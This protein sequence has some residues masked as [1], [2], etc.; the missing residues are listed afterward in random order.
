M[1]GWGCGVRGSWV[2]WVGRVKGLGGA[3]WFVGVVWGRGGVSGCGWRWCGGLGFV[4]G[5]VGWWSVVGWDVVGGVWCS[6]W[7]GCQGVG[8]VCLRGVWIVFG[9][10]RVGLLGVLGRLVVWGFRWWGWGRVVVVMWW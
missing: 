6:G 8:W 9:V 5:S 1:C 10:C 2:V 4:V 3:V 7:G